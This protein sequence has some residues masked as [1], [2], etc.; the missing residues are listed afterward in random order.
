MA[1][2]RVLIAIISYDGIVAE[3]TQSF[4][5]AMYE[6][7]KL[8]S[9][10]EFEFLT[11]V[12]TKKEQFRARNLVTEYA[13]GADC[14][15]MWQID[16]DTVLQPDTFMTLYNAL[17]GNPD[18][19]VAGA[20]YTQR[21]GLFNPVV[22]KGGFTGVDSWE[23]NF[24][25]PHEL[26]GGVMEVFVTGGGCFLFRMEAFKSIM[27]PFFWADGE[28]GTDIQICLKLQRAGWKVLCDTGHSVGHVGQPETW[29]PESV[30]PHIARW[31]E[32]RANLWSDASIFCG[33]DY[34]QLEDLAFNH[35]GLVQQIW[36]DVKPETAQEV[37]DIY[38]N[39]ALENSF[40][41][42]GLVYNLQMQPG[43]KSNI[44][45]L[46]YLM[47]N[48]KK[49]N[50]VLDYGCGIGV[51]SA[52]LSEYAGHLTMVDLPTQAFGF[53]RWHVIPKVSNVRFCDP[54]EDL[55][56]DTNYDLIVC[57]DV[58]EHLTEPVTVL[59]KLLSHLKPGGI[60]YTNAH[61]ETFRTQQQ[62]ERLHIH[63]LPEEELMDIYKA[64]NCHVTD[65][66]YIVRKDN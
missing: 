4:I 20:L 66:G 40:I 46:H 7:G 27:R 6:L 17:E 11:M 61:V 56:F 55:V 2:K 58:I 21:D 44:E 28:L 64:N 16:D 47:T 18:A 31:N 33:L 59:N 5:K 14:D 60:F 49:F 26:T 10:G 53:A 15:Y 63:I 51:T 12:M 30:P 52:I 37:A 32:I 9:A 36:D 41:G 38:L 8:H 42:R 45:L 62:G 24:Y 1:K 3:A 50:K 48:G 43:Q 34:Q 57:K 19:A 25:A 29:Y 54:E 65:I 35:D 39:P 22:M 23:L 13:L